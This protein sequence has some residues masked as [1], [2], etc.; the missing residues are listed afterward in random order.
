MIDKQTVIMASLPLPEITRFLN[1]NQE[2]LE[3]EASSRATVTAQL[4]QGERQ[5]LAQRVA[6]RAKQTIPP[7]ADDAQVQADLDSL[8]DDI[9]KNEEELARNDA[10]VLLIAKLRTGG[11]PAPQPA[12]SS[13]APPP[14]AQAASGT[15]AASSLPP[16]TQFRQILGKIPEYKV[17][18]DFDVFMSRFETYCTL[19]RISDEQQTKL[20]LDSA[21]SEEARLR[22]SEISALQEPFKSDSFSA[23]TQRLR[24]RFY[25]QAKSTLYKNTYD[26]IKQKASQSVT[27]YCSAKFS[28]Y[29]KAYLGYPFQFFVRTMVQHLHNEDLRSEV[30]RHAG[31]LESSVVT[32]MVIQQRLYGE[33]MNVVNSALDLC[34]RTSSSTVEAMDRNGLRVEG[35]E[36]LTSLSSASTSSSSSIAQLGIENED[37]Y[38]WAGEEEGDDIYVAEEMEN[39]EFGLSEE[40]INYCYLN[41][42]EAQSQFWERQAS[43]EEIQQMQASPTGKRC[44]ECNSPSH[45]VR[46]CP[47]RLRLVQ[48]RTHQMLSQSGR[49][50][51]PPQ[52]G[53][54][55][56]RGNRGWRTRGG[57][58]RGGGW[59]GRGRGSPWG[60]APRAGHLPQ[61]FQNPYQPGQP[62]SRMGPPTS[63]FPGQ[64]SFR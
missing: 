42:S 56:S 31:H 43:A 28:S 33:L 62:A 53:G 47:T 51:Y 37:S 41:E 10:I 3:I 19:N 4:K 5:F 58:G 25:P 59:R 38:D 16:A 8:A 21:F 61:G 46:S 55:N 36:T 15:T 48:T 12:G 50:P 32:E 22:A 14:P 1:L 34:R 30:L 44:H 23:Y 52:R 57:G 11:S 6:L 60:S 27:D 26:T 9:L 64:R 35:K 18:D 17:A 29:R 2:E 39:E 24:E 54:F 13:T 63:G 49:A 20:L 45:L 7:S 40:E